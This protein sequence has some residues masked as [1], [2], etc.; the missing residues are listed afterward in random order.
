MKRSAAK[1]GTDPFVLVP[2]A[3]MTGVRL[4]V[5]AAICSGVSA[6]R[7]VTK[8]VSPG[9]RAIV[10]FETLESVMFAFVAEARSGAITALL[11][12]DT[13]MFWGWLRRTQ[14]ALAGIVE[15]FVTITCSGVLVGLLPKRATR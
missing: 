13:T 11:T 7:R 4:W 5:S 2:W 15:F 9:A 1:S 8:A 12:F 3:V 14:L 10:E 6:A